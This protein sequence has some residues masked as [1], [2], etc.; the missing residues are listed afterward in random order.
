MH[1]L[2]R[3][4]QREPVRASVQC[5]YKYM[6]ENSVQYGWI[7]E[8]LQ[9]TEETGLV[10]KSSGAAKPRKKK[11]IIIAIATIVGAV[12]AAAVVAVVS[13]YAVSR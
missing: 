5:A 7:S 2:I 1:F 10:Q 8:M 13:S 9:N 4:N 11:C 3:P 12:V 6:S